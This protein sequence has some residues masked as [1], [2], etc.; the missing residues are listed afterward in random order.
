MVRP[1]TRDLFIV[2]PPVLGYVRLGRIE[3]G[4]RFPRADAG[5]E[6]QTERRNLR[7]MRALRLRPLFAACASGALLLVNAAPAHARVAAA[8]PGAFISGFATPVVVTSVGGPVTFFT[9][10]ALPH[11]FV[12]MDDLLTKKQAKKAEW[13]TSYRAGKCPLFWS[14]TITAGEQ[15]EVL[16]LE[17][18]E[19][20]RQ[21][22]FFCS[23]HPSSMRGKLVVN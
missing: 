18:V 23:I 5:Q 2:I 11:N 8:G 16:G 4:A 12:A 7:R 9:A 1:A 15:T 6:D 13:C 22:A 19:A 14:E 20:G 3:A 17:N 10:D 21:Y